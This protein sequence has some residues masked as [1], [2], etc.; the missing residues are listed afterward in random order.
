MRMWKLPTPTKIVDKLKSN[1]LGEMASAEWE[2]L[3]EIE[4][5]DAAMKSP[6]PSAAQ[7]PKVFI[8]SQS[9]TVETDRSLKTRSRRTPGHED[10]SSPRLGGTK[11]WTKV[12]SRGHG[13]AV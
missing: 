12:A 10:G 1:L 6:R 13:S 11:G 4:W 9:G 5:D 2:L 8:P 7:N 3:E